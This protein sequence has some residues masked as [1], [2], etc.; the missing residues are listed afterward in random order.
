[1]EAI[2]IEP[3]LVFWTWAFGNTL[4]VVACC[5]VG[6]ARIRAKRARAHRRLMGVAAAFVGLFLASYLVKVGVIGREDRSL[7]SA[8]D[9]WTLYVHELCVATMLVAGALAAHRARRFGA[10]QDGPSP[11][12]EARARDRRVHRLAG[13]IAVAASALALLTAGGVLVGMYSRA[14]L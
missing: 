8:I 13:R 12:P 3:K 11:A 5:F 7:W 1:M 9:L 4:L 2:P 6:V 10:V 14:G